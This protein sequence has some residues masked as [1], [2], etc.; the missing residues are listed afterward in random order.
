MPFRAYSQKPVAAVRLTSPCAL[1]LLAAPL[2]AQ[3]QLTNGAVQPL[4]LGGGFTRAALDTLAAT[5]ATTW[6]G[7]AVPALDGD[8][9]CC[10]SGN[11]TARSMRVD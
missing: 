6:V 1:T 3:P 11:R 9:S 4:T 2:A 5:S 10:W 8:C 7:Y